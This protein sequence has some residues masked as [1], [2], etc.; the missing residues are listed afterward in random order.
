MTTPP[1]LLDCMHEARDELHIAEVRLQRAESEAAHSA[2]FRRMAVG[3][4]ERA[5]G[6]SRIAMAAIELD[7][8]RTMRDIAHDYAVH[9]TDAWRAARDALKGAGLA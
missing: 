8:A 2:V 5:I 3:D 9:A 6:D 4:I 1:S 7:Y